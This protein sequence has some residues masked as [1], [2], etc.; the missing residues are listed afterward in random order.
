MSKALLETEKQSRIEGGKILIVLGSIIGAVFLFFLLFV[1]TNAVIGTDSNTPWIMILSFFLSIISFFLFKNFL[2]KKWSNYI[3]KDFEEKIISLEK[4]ELKKKKWLA[5][6]QEKQRK[7]LAWEREQKKEKS[8]RVKTLKKNIPKLLKEK[9]VKM[10]AS[11]I[12]AFLKHR[13]VDMVKEVCEELYQN[14]KINRTGN[15]RYF[16]LTE[17]KKKPKPKKAS[18]PKSE[19]T[20]IPKQIKKLS[21]LK[22][23]GI[24]TEEEFQSKKKD[25]L[26]KM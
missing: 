23:Q 11:E 24:L 10:P 5:A 17:E 14:G 18:A 22:D 13:D 7:E 1:I 9:A 26:D 4:E 15:Y 8:T 12:D 20:D 3:E 21:D 16:I 19:S 2:D 25:L 6:Q